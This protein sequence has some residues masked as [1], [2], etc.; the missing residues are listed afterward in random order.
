MGMLVA[1]M[2]RTSIGDRRVRAE[3]GDRPGLDRPQELGLE[4]EGQVP[5]LVQEERPARGDLEAAGPALPG[6]GEGAL[7]VAEQL[8]LEE[9]LA[10]GAHVHGDENLAGRGRLAVELAGDELLARPVLAE[11][12]D[13]G[14]RR[15]D[16][17]DGGEDGLHGRAAA[18]EIV[19]R[20]VEV[21]AQTLLPGPE[22]PG[23]DAGLRRSFRAE[24]RVARSFSFCQG[25]RTKSVAPSLIARTASSTSP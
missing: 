1:Q 9:R 6:V 20:P 25:L 15:G 17:L 14:V 2:S 5:D 24:E 11:D 10:Q 21:G 18:D 16:L 8:A 4:G 19:E 7:D 13:V 22:G 23:L 12:Q 3:P